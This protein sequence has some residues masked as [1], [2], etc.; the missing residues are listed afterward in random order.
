MT[1]QETCCVS[2]YSC[3]LNMLPSAGHAHLHAEDTC[4]PERSADK[5]QKWNMQAACKH[6][7]LLAKLAAATEGNVPVRAK[8]SDILIYQIPKDITGFPRTAVPACSLH[9]RIGPEVQTVVQEE[10]LEGLRDALRSLVP[11]CGETVVVPLPTAGA[12]PRKPF[13]RGALVNPYNWPD[14]VLSNP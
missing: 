14:K 4:P 6:A 3:K 10:G 7:Q 5:E 12:P 2:C 8:P 9:L 13:Y 11:L 1:L